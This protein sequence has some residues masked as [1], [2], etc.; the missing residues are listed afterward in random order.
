SGTRSAIASEPP[1]RRRLRRR[2]RVASVAVPA[3]L[4]DKIWSTHAILV[5]PDGATLLHVDRH[6]VHDG[7]GNAFR[8]L[9]EKGLTVRRTDRTLATPDHYVSTRSH[10]SSPAPPVGESRE[11]VHRRG[12]VEDLEANAKSASLTLFGLGDRRQGIVHVVG[13]EQGLS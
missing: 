4:F 5:R 6:F 10:V 11:G 2:S 1:S 9:Q 12:V 3:T 13:P 8:R 7:S